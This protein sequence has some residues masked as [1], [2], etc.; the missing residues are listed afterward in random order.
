[1]SFS[2]MR[3]NDLNS[4]VLLF[5]DQLQFNFVMKQL[6]SRNH[7]KSLGWAFQ[8]EVDLMAAFDIQMRK[9]IDVIQRCIG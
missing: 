5:F 3:I 2:T 4:S 8:R 7:N 9:K 1:M 6:C